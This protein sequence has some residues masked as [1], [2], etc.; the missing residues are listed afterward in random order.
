MFGLSMQEL[1][2]IGVIAVLLFGRRLP[3][4]AKSIG[5]SYRE[6]KRGLVDIHSTVDVSDSFRGVTSYA[7]NTFSNTKGV[8]ARKAFDD[9]D[10]HDEATAPK[11]EPPTSEP[12]M[13]SSSS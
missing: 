8:A 7:K 12:K 13:D 4:V 11:F 6:F 5:T 3:E 9:I 10:D 2:I 1:A